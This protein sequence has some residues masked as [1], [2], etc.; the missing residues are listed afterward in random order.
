MKGQGERTQ[1][2]GRLGRWWL[3]HQ[4]ACTTTIA[5]LRD[6]RFSTL[7]VVLTIG[8]ALALP[9]LLHVGAE[10]LGALTER[11]DSTP[12]IN[13]FLAPE[14]AEARAEAF[15]GWP[16]IARM[17]FQSAEGSLQELAEVTGSGDLL[18]DLLSEFST[19]PLPA[20]AVLTPQP[21]YLAPA[22]MHALAERLGSE[23]GVD[24]VQVD[25]E[26]LQR[27]QAGLQL[28]DRLAWGLGVLLAGAVLLVVSSLTRMAVAQRADEIRVLKLVGGTPAFVRR[29][30]LYQ[31]ALLGVAGGV[32][33]CI[34]LA[35]ILWFL[36]EPVA[37]LAARY[38]SD[39]RL[40]SVPGTLLLLLP[41]AGMAL[42]WLAARFSAHYQLRRIEP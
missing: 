31:G 32:A 4:V 6:E 26:W 9:G 27:L 15:A 13:V 18:E 30:F 35:L 17:E 16:E 3:H 24:G 5:R 42:G 34:L 20:V 10:R 1:R 22:R 33:A 39:F 12:R 40:G 21:D 11:W 41:A 37:T 36:G 38:G 19:N 8:V 14:D 2:L 28:A 7:L 25:L 23:S 29:P